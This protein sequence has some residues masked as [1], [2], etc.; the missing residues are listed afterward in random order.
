MWPQIYLWKQGCDVIQH[1]HCFKAPDLGQAT[2]A[3]WIEAILDSGDPL[4]DIEEEVE[5][6]TKTQAEEEEEA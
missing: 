5:E 1:L 3:E 4:S 6:E 2:L